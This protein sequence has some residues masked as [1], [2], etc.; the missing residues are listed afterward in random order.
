V[1]I[2]LQLT[3][4]RD[5]ILDATL[6]VSCSCLNIVA[7]LGWEQHEKNGVARHQATYAN[8]R[9][10]YPNLP[11]QL[12]IFC[13]HEGDRALRSAFALQKKGKKVSPPHWERGVVRDGARSFR[14]E[15]D[16]GIVGLATVAGRIR[17]PFTAHPSGPE[18]A[19][20]CRWFC[21]R[22]LDA[23]PV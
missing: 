18:I 10:A 16:K 23:S 8:L 2:Q 5:A 7:E 20:P 6:S 11:S 12:V 17:F 15:K 21:H 9:K 1:C 14:I 22:R 4:N 19:R 3:A 13:T